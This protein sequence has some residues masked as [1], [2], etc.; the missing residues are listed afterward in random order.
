MYLARTTRRN[1]LGRK[2]RLG[3]ISTVGTAVSTVPWYY[4]LLGPLGPSQAITNYEMDTGIPAFGAGSPTA[5][6]IDS[7]T[8]LPILTGQ[9]SQTQIH[10]IINQGSAAVTAAGGGPSDI[11]QLQQDVNSAVNLTGGTRQS[12]AQVASSG[13]SSFFGNQD[14]STLALWATVAII[15]GIVVVKMVSR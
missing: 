3:D 7:A 12:L 15:G 10:N 6:A 1:S 5:E 13:L 2:S 14:P 9:P 4:W 8:G 11:A